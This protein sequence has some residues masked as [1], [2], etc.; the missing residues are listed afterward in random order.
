MSAL[1][2]VQLTRLR[3]DTLSLCF[4]WRLSRKDGQEFGLTSHDQALVFDEFTFSP[5]AMLAVAGFPQTDSLSPGDVEIQGTLNNA[6][7]DAADL[8]AGLWDECRVSIYRADWQSPA[9]G[10]QHIWSGYFS[11]VTEEANGRF[12]AALLSQKV[13]LQRPIGRVL[14]RQCDAV[15]GDARCGVTANGRTCDQRFETCRD[16]FSNTENFRGFPHLPGNDFILS[17]PAATNNDGGQR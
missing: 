5:G 4:C 12:S 7:I 2:A 1:S 15:L 9:F 3:D 17:G 10:L 6:L 8:R 13:D 16:R 14:Q 11:R